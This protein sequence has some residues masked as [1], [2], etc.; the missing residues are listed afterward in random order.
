VALA[1]GLFALQRALQ[2]IVV[3]AQPKNVRMALGVHVLKLALLAKQNHIILAK[4]MFAP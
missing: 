4:T 1:Q 3:M 2:T